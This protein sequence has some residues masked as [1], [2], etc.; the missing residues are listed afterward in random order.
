MII[1]ETKTDGDILNLIQYVYNVQSTTTAIAR[2][3]TTLLS[4]ESRDLEYVLSDGIWGYK[5][6]PIIEQINE[7]F[8]FRKLFTTEKFKTFLMIN[9]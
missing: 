8:M 9:D 4:L 2:K 7:F 5:V 3:E 1:K 6:T